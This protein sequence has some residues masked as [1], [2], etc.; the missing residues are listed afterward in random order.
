MNKIDNIKITVVGF[1]SWGTA[2]AVLLAKKGYDVTVTA[3]NIDHLAEVEFLRVNNKYLPQVKIPDNV[4]FDSNLLEAVSGAN[5]ILFAVPSQH[6]GNTLKKA[7][8]NIN[9]DAI[10]VN[11]AKGIDKKSLKRLSDIAKEILPEIRY[12]A[13]SGPSH[14]EEVG[15]N[16]PAGVVAASDDMEAAEIIQS[17]FMTERFRVYT[18]DDVIG[19]E[20]GGALKNIMA[21]GA[22]ISDG[23]GYGDSAKAALM[24]R[25]IAE[26]SRLGTSLGAKRETFAGLSG[27]GDLIVTCTSG[28]SRNRRCGLLIGQGMSP[29]EASDSIGMVVEGISTCEA[30]YKLSETTGVDM[31]I[32]SIIH[33]CLNEEIRAK[34]AIDLL[35]NRSPK[36][37][38]K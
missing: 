12:V 36:D 26:I 30:A 5:I 25:G 10:I 28:H 11:V 19:V 35:M 1:G 17:V 15:R 20:L 4:K 22:G 16:M 32:T 21:I 14:A 3:R 23:L 18:H 7:V 34:D 31:P 29:K 2:L 37:E 8:V 33:A 38:R 27:I 24:T 13:L 9:K 6:F